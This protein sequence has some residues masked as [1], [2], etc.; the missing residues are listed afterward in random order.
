MSDDRYDEL[1]EDAER[2]EEHEQE[3]R[4]AQGAP[5]EATE[6][7]LGGRG[8]GAWSAGEAAHGEADTP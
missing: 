3:R 8:L 7:E 2:C 5:R 4:D 6:G 1:R